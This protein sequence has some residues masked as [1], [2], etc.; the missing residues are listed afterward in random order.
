MAA[1][2]K[3][4]GAWAVNKFLSELL[5]GVTSD[6]FII[7]FGS[8]SFGVKDVQ[9]NLKHFKDIESPVDI[10]HVS[11]GEVRL[12]IP[13]L[14][15]L[16]KVPIKVKVEKLFV[17]VGA[18]DVS[19]LNIDQRKVMMKATKKL[20]L[21]VMGIIDGVPVPE[22]YVDK[23]AA[24]KTKKKL[25]EKELFGLPGI[26]KKLIPIVDNVQVEVANIH[27]RYEDDQ[28]R[29]TGSLAVGLC[30]DNLFIRGS[31]TREGEETFVTEWNIDNFRKVCLNNFS[32]YI[33]TEGKTV[34]PVSSQPQTELLSQIYRGTPAP[35]TQPHDHHFAL[36]PL[37]LS[38]NVQWHRGYDLDTPMIT[39][40][41]EIP[42][43]GLTVSQP[44]YA[45]AL[46]V[47]THYGN[48]AARLKFGYLSPPTES[49]L[50]NAR[51]WWEYVLG[52][53]RRRVRHRLKRYR[54]ENIMQRLVDRHDYI[55]ITREMVHLGPTW[56]AESDK[57]LLGELESRLKFRDTVLFRKMAKL[58]V[59]RDVK[60]G[61]IPAYGMFSKM[62]P[63]V[64]IGLVVAGAAA[65]SLIASLFLE[66]KMVFAIFIVLVSAA[67]GAGFKTIFAKPTMPGFDESLEN[68]TWIYDQ[69]KF[70]H[71]HNKAP[72]VVEESIFPAEYSLVR[73]SASAP[74]LQVD[75]N[76][77][78]A[79]PYDTSL[80]TLSVDGIRASGRV[81]DPTI[82]V[83]AS[84]DTI[85]AVERVT[86][87]QKQPLH[88][89][90]HIF[91]S[92]SEEMK[93]SCP[94]AERRFVNFSMMMKPRDRPNVDI[95]ASV[96]TTTFNVNGS[97]S[98]VN[99]MLGFF[100]PPTNKKEVKEMTKQSI[101]RMAVAGVDSIK[102]A[103]RDRLCIALDLQIA[104]PTVTIAQNYRAPSHALFVRLGVVTVGSDPKRIVDLESYT[105]D[106]CFDLYKVDVRD[107][108]VSILRGAWYDPQ[109]A[110]NFALTLDPSTM[111][112]GSPVSSGDLITNATS[113]SE[114]VLHS[115]HSSPNPQSPFTGHHIVRPI[116]ISLSAYVCIAG[117]IPNVPAIRLQGDV[118]PV[119][120]VVSPARVHR[121][122]N[123]LSAQFPA[124]HLRKRAPPMHHHHKPHTGPQTDTSSASSSTTSASA[125]S[126]SALISSGEDLIVK[127]FNPA[128]ESDLEDLSGHAK[129]SHLVLPPHRPQLLASFVV[130]SAAIHITQDVGVLK[131]TT[132]APHAC[133]LLLATLTVGTVLADV[134]VN[135]YIT[136]VAAKVQ[137]VQFEEF[138]DESHKRIL[139]EVRAVP[140]NSNLF[141]LEHPEFGAVSVSIKV[142]PKNS[143][144]Y[145][146]TMTDILVNVGHLQVN[147][148]RPALL[149]LLRVGLSF[150]PI[151]Y[152]FPALGVAP[153][154]PKESDYPTIETSLSTSS[155][156]VSS[157]TTTSATDIPSSEAPKTEDSSKTED[158][159]SKVEDSVI[160]ASKSQ[161][162]SASADSLPVPVDSNSASEEVSHASVA[163]VEPPKEEVKDEASKEVAKE[164]AAKEA[165]KEDAPKEDAKEEKVEDAKEEKVEPLLSEEKPQVPEPEEEPFVLEPIAHEVVATSSAVSIE[166]LPLAGLTDED[167]DAEPMISPHSSEEDS[168]EQT[169]LLSEDGE[170]SPEA[171]TVEEEAEM[172]LRLMQGENE[173]TRAVAV[174][175]NVSSVVLKLMLDSAPIAHLEV[176]DI[177]AAV[178]LRGDQQLKV[179]GFVSQ[180]GVGA[181]HDGIGPV[182]MII[183]ENSDKLVSFNFGMFKTISTDYPGYDMEVSAKVGALKITYYHVVV[184]KLVG[185]ALSM[186]ENA[187]PIVQMMAPKNLAAEVRKSRRLNRKQIEYSLDSPKHASSSEKTP[188]KKRS[189]R[190]S[191]RMSTDPLGDSEL[192]SSTTSTTNLTTSST[193]NLSTSS[194]TNLSASSSTNKSAEKKKRRKSVT[195]DTSAAMDATEDSVDESETK[196][197]RG[198]KSR[199]GRTSVRLDA[200][201][202]L[203]ASSSS[204][205]SGEEADPSTPKKSKLQRTESGK[206]RKAV[207]KKIR[208]VIPAAAP[209]KIKISAQVESP[210]VVIPVDPMS[211]A[212]AGCIVVNLGRVEVSNVFEET[213]GIM[214]D[215]LTAQ[216]SHMNVAFQMPEGSGS[217]IASMSLLDHSG[218]KA[219]VQR[220]L[221]GDHKH[222]L[223]LIGVDV[224]LLPLHVTFGTAQLE[225]VFQ[226][227]AKHILL[228]IP[229]EHELAE[230]FEAP[231]ESEKQ[232]MQFEQR[233]TNAIAVKE[234]VARFKAKYGE[235]VDPLQPTPKSRPNIRVVAR[236]SSFAMDLCDA[237]CSPQLRIGVKQIGALANIANDGH[238]SAEA[239]ISAVEILDLVISFDHFNAFFGKPITVHEPMI[240]VAFVLNP[241]AN[242]LGVKAGINS[243][244]VALIPDTILRLKDTWEAPLMQGLRAMAKASPQHDAK[245]VTAPL[246]E[247]TDDDFSDFHGV[248]PV[249]G[250]ASPMAYG[251]EVPDTTPT[252]KCN[253]L[254]SSPMIAIVPAANDVSTIAFTVNLGEMTLNADL[255]LANKIIDASASVS[256]C[257]LIRSIITAGTLASTNEQF[258]LHPL[259][260]KASVA[261]NPKKLT[262]TAVIPR[263]QF[264]ASF[265]DVE[266]VMRILDAYKPLINALA[267]PPDSQKQTL[268]TSSIISTTEVTS[269]AIAPLTST[270]EAAQAIKAKRAAERAQVMS[271]TLEITSID[272]AVIDD[273]FKGNFF[274]PLLRFNLS[275]L[276]G[277]VIKEATLNGAFTFN[278]I[279]A[280]VYN[281]QYGGWE[282]LIEP[283][284]MQLGFAQDQH[285]MSGHL[286]ATTIL[287]MNINHSLM[288]CVFEL[289]EIVAPPKSHRK[290][291][292]VQLPSAEPLVLR[293]WSGQKVT[294]QL[295]DNPEPFP[296]GLGESRSLNLKRQSR[297]E[298]VHS[299]PNYT[300]SILVAG[301][302]APARLTANRVDTIVVPYHVEDPNSCYIAEISTIHGSRTITIRGAYKI[303]NNTTVAMDMMIVGDNQDEPEIYTI[304]PNGGH[305]S[306][307]IAQGSGRTVK[308]RAQGYDWSELI[309][310]MHPKPAYILRCK[311]KVENGAKATG[312]D[313]FGTARVDVNKD[314]EDFSLVIA[315]PVNVENL[316][317]VP[318]E[319]KFVNLKREKEQ[320]KAAAKEEKAAKK[321]EKEKPGDKTADKTGEKSATPSM[322]LTAST[323]F[324]PQSDLVQPLSAMPTHSIIE[325][326]D[327]DIHD[328]PS[329]DETLAICLKLPSFGWSKPMPF[330]TKVDIK[331]TQKFDTDLVTS[332]FIEL[333]DV[334]GTMLKVGIDTSITDT[335]ARH[336]KI[337]SV[338][339][340]VN[341]TGL[342]LF[343]KKDKDTSGLAAGQS[344]T[345]GYGLRL[346]TDA[347]KKS[348]TEAS[349]TVKSTSLLESTDQHKWYPQLADLIAKEP[350][351]PSPSSTPFSTS[352]SQNSLNN[353][354][355]SLGASVDPIEIKTESISKGYGPYFY[356]GETRVAIALENSNWSSSS[357]LGIRDEGTIDIED[358]VTGR[359]YSFFISVQPAP[360]R[361]WRTSIVRV[362]P[363]FVVNNTSKFPLILRQIHESHESPTVLRL[364]PGE[365]LPYHWPSYKKDQLMAAHIANKPH[366]CTSYFGLDQ[367]GRFPL[368]FHDT[369]VPLQRKPGT[370]KYIVG[371]PVPIPSSLDDDVVFAG[372]NI[373]NM[374]DSSIFI[375]I[376]PDDPE[377][378]FCINNQ[379][380][381]NIVVREIQADPTLKLLKKQK[382]DQQAVEDPAAPSDAT[383]A[384]DV[385]SSS[386][387]ATPAQKSEK[388][389]AK[390][391]KAVE[392]EK[393]ALEKAAAK[394]AEVDKKA[395]EKAAEK[396][397]K[398][399]EKDAKQ[400][401]KDAKTA[402]KEA[403]KRKKK[404]EEDAKKHTSQTPN[405]STEEQSSEEGTSSMEGDISAA[406]GSTPSKKKKKKDDPPPVQ[407]E[408]D[409]AEARGAQGYILKAKRK[410][411]FM[412][413]R[414]QHPKHK[415]QF[416]LPGD[417]T[418]YTVNLDK[419]QVIPSVKLG[420]KKYLHM[421]T[422]AVGQSKQLIVKIA[423]K[424]AKSDEEQLAATD[425]SRMSME[426]SMA[427]MGL[428][429]IDQTP[430]EL[431]YVRLG[432]LK[433][434]AGMSSIEQ[435][436]EVKLGMLQVDNDLYLTPQPIIAHSLDQPEGD[437]FF[438]LAIVRDMR[439]HKFF[440][441]RYF[442]MKMHKL[443]SKLDMAFAMN[444]MCWGLSL[445][446][447]INKRTA[448]EL[449]HRVILGEGEGQI[450]T[451]TVSATSNGFYFEVFHL[452][453][454]SFQISFTPSSNFDCPNI[455][456]AGTELIAKISP[457]LVTIDQA[458]LFLG[459]LLMTN[460]FT[461][462]EEFIA[463]LTSHYVK[464]VLKQLLMLVGSSDA[465]GN[466]VSLV[467]S[468]GTGVYDLV[469]EPAEGATQSPAQF[470]IGI[471]KGTGSLLKNSL[472][473]VLATAEKLVGN[474]SKLGEKLSMDKEY[475][476]E[477]ERM[478]LKKAHHVGTGLSYGFKELGTGLFQGVT[479]LVT[480][481]VKGAK[482]KGLKGFATGLGKGLV[483]VVVKPTVGVVDLVTRTTEGIRNTGSDH[484]QVPR[485]R[486]PRFIG[487]DL[488]ITNYDATK[489][490]GQ[491]LLRTLSDGKYNKEFYAW[492]RAPTSKTMILVTMKEV[493][494]LK[495]NA[496]E[497]VSLSE[498]W[499]VEWHQQLLVF[500]ETIN[501]DEA[502]RRIILVERSSMAASSSSLTVSSTALPPTA[503][504]ILEDSS[505]SDLSRSASQSFSTPTK[506]DGKEHKDT[507][508]KKAE[509]IKEYRIKVE[510]LEEMPA[511]IAQ[512]VMYIKAAPVS[513]PRAKALSLLKQVGN[514]NP[515]SLFTSGSVDK[516]KKDKKKD[517]KSNLQASTEMS[518]DSPASPASS[519]SNLQRSTSERESK[520]ERR[521]SLALEPSQ[522]AAAVGPTPSDETKSPAKRE[523]M[524]KRAETISVVSPAKDGK[525]KE[526][527]KDKESK[528]KSRLLT[529]S[530][531]GTDAD[532]AA[533]SPKKHS[534]L[535][536]SAAE[537]SEQPAK[538]P[539]RSKSARTHSVSQDESTAPVHEATNA[540]TSND[541]TEAA[542][543]PIKSPRRSKSSKSHTVDAQDAVAP[544]QETPAE[545]SPRKHGEEH[546]HEKKKDKHPASGS[547]SSPRNKIDND[548][549]AADEAPKPSQAPTEAEAEAGDL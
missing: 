266:L 195:L 36:Q 15:K 387:S 364:E 384:V 11:L 513:R 139:Q 89:L 473:G 521:R 76:L 458:P 530:T 302:S 542:E 492:H 535:D 64:K 71:T 298:A 102:S 183:V 270:A 190:L 525:D 275:P 274:V 77:N 170:E 308:V 10:K 505:M 128:P 438:H 27:I 330:V 427:G 257:R 148:V 431:L 461:S 285:G 91:P 301:A 2:I 545:A 156:S 40:H 383:P 23:E 30:L 83:V 249:T 109:T 328:L 151:G 327:N 426:I 402:E 425:G 265:R 247:A 350:A 436:L 108:S 120:I 405:T 304:E 527:H 467:N 32:L 56:V 483:G 94:I 367:V 65:L 543:Q 474:V 537:S 389:L 54:A 21:F 49:P 442:S 116:S 424:Q 202:E 326:D 293:N 319:V 394:Q 67:L 296:I 169:E 334:N 95:G 133:P 63:A 192:E 1:L 41:A 533:K 176:R 440:C 435:T 72:K 385:A 444:A 62:A 154:L 311:E 465:L 14:W 305:F 485:V 121:I 16:T 119:E 141:S 547:E 118:T 218:V 403:E 306:A 55:R 336:I 312:F 331:R 193:T 163:P 450:K 456:D 430:Q 409:E 234:R 6:T 238:I 406:T 309:D 85:N 13:A 208:K 320:A 476:Q 509:K 486:D 175:A 229:K 223:P 393:A 19:N 340:I 157:E 191:R 386:D 459:G 499:G 362:Y 454:M 29:P 47:A 523:K 368:R 226:M 260:L 127:K 204:A 178:D 159:P 34:T 130:R 529:A 299:P 358:S 105:E 466:P 333:P 160:E 182:D 359:L 221:Y 361:F 216:V 475:Q 501:T 519:T 57:K 124:V 500:S 349:T 380:N 314:G 276:K 4:A 457:H 371:G 166:P 167:D 115:P 348:S 255:D 514:L 462:Q 228:P 463:R 252:M 20:A 289:L 488:L 511:I 538:S 539:R 284:E 531:D 395:A 259:E 236:I 28:C 131:K 88:L 344:I 392:K 188:E 439:Y 251:P 110:R 147:V 541:Q 468:L 271:V 69:L 205:I 210:T 398:Q 254:V 324:V 494:Y 351:P 365:Q 22:E 472:G 318:M 194:A 356:Y 99:A 227:L 303:T 135:H 338:A 445:L 297:S 79:R 104:G 366:L 355:F 243:P 412:F 207:A 198:K 321:V 97:I 107:V 225:L 432:D 506:G 240:Q 536:V 422:V 111:Q 179:K 464:S 283:W 35:K 185:W 101:S 413:P 187:M 480:Q 150:I 294:V 143:P 53:V 487:S 125:S 549:D 479:G 286:T 532:A 377:E 52:C 212:K 24:L 75:A 460:C 376:L 113:S 17:V 310:F 315:P 407:V 18:R 502:K 437:P 357:D 428:S 287:E 253:L 215:T 329:F 508:T 504:E 441:F 164:D 323:A 390:E 196:S 177:A 140:R 526:K 373:T 279:C 399:A 375:R 261:I 114:P 325:C 58:S 339:W 290:S 469:H 90:S 153:R 337:Y 152:S 201:P 186:V 280:H 220:V 516:K 343:F 173:A 181:I 213:L 414:P 447:W 145:K 9:L 262:T 73:F 12:E 272:F 292:A 100:I 433:V 401:E 161:S 146:D 295:E 149:A 379:T 59:M 482:S 478:K 515:I 418:W 288:V 346:Q 363:R 168:L 316:F 370:K 250:E 353:S 61:R 241:K 507:P 497:K 415:V 267:P 74:H 112:V 495:V 82:L 277:K 512:L 411:A 446:K 138:I 203:S 38:A 237:T 374:G 313:W 256:R 540:A 134:E 31:T 404:E 451:P 278:G 197:P 307:S 544:V 232:S 103:V 123:I 397:A 449:E 410:E 33:D 369:S 322:D 453:P 391:R 80:V 51:A 281:R 341:D 230:Y 44:Q 246:S 231:S 144:V 122:L 448:A 233:L 470:G 524:S 39:A 496:L 70:H 235:N 378:Y 60:T 48:Y 162:V 522:A 245:K 211:V 520:R 242:A 92:P 291:K 419:I 282:P 503:H 43:L 37:S 332:K 78:G 269:T 518:S 354:S 45:S 8:G 481:P 87:G 68:W 400:A 46:N 420:D 263:C 528:R 423:E 548:T 317:T 382:K 434:T 417:S 3:Q 42:H 219:V 498:R 189:K 171:L 158:S 155:D 98:F 396:A 347:L 7:D 184:M 93:L 81:G 129:Y 360:A 429:I 471:A 534:K 443:A 477:R 214:I 26:V 137:Y 25:L 416:Q 209:L 84:V 300:F 86:M 335:A 408:E 493:M 381:L 96:I 165:V 126:L 352:S 217:S 345:P 136:S 388:D 484:K 421:R 142:I 132:D 174:R 50:V 5:T 489:A 66:W 224:E 490:E 239:A 200:P 222:T 342:P 172:Q 180:F 106:D 491:L 455:D 517:S 268:N 273:R 372:L 248:D 244:I 510:T 117:N 452:N 258:L 206:K 264:I 546:K 199:K